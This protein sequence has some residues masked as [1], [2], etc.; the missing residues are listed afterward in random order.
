MNGAHV[1][2][3]RLL[4]RFGRLASQA[5]SAEDLF[6]VL[7]QAVVDPA[8]VAAAAAA[9]LRLE[10]DG[11]VLIA[12]CA[13]LPAS[14]QR[15]RQEMETVGSELG[16]ALRAAW[17]EGGRAV[18]TLPLVSGG[19]IYGALV[20][21]SSARGELGRAQLELAEGLADLVAVT[22]D[23]A[24]R[25]AELAR[26]YAEL[27]ASREALAKGEKL[28]ALGEMAAGVSHDLKNLLNP[29]GLQ[30]ELVARR[31]RSKPEEALEIIGHMKEAVRSGADVVERLRAFSRQSPEAHAEAVDLEQVLET[32]AEISRPRVGSQRGLVLRCEPGPHLTV[33]CRR[34]ELITAV[35]NLLFNAIDAMPD[36]GVIALRTGA[37]ARGGWIEVADTGPGMPPE[38]ERRVFEPFFTT[39]EHGTGLG[40][41]MVY[42]FA[43]RH[44][45]TVTL[46]TRP[47]A[48]TRFRLWFPAAPVVTGAAAP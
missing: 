7:V 12:A 25:H 17:G 22:L 15:W 23:K 44:G 33:L 28:R 42:A 38:I 6:P 29:L 2:R 26:S 32:A 14:L 16:E 10:P 35:V 4:L 1:A 31:L 18:S 19:D 3:D 45:G 41:A 37:D 9:V 5:A 47:G 36:G 46:E 40:L 30:L 34:S 48:G 20:V 21:F 27:R 11:H 13:G 8:G 24:T 39:K 43:K